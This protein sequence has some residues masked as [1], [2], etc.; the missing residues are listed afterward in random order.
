MEKLTMMIHYIKKYFRA[1][2]K[3]FWF[4]LHILL[5]YTLNALRAEIK[6][7]YLIKEEREA[8]Q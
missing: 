8:V 2:V 5:N 7:I 6:D 3:V 4:Q 1:E